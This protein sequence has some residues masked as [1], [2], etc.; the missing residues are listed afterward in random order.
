MATIDDYTQD[1]TTTGRLQEGGQISAKFEQGGD[2]D[3]FRITLAA[4]SYYTFQLAATA[5]TDG[6]GSFGLYLSQP[7]GGML[8]PVWS[9]MSAKGMTG[10]FKS[11]VAGDYFISAAN[12]TYSA[13][14]P[15]SYTL[16]AGA[17]VADDA[18]D[19]EQTA[20]RIALRQAVSGIFE[21]PGDVDAYKVTLE[22]GV[23]YTA[24]QG[25]DAGSTYSMSV[26]VADSGGQAV[27]AYLSGN[28]YSFTAAASGDYYFLASGGNY[29]GTA[30]PYTLT[31]EAAVDDRS[32]GIAGAGAL[33]VGASTKGQLEV[34]G[35]KDWYA[36]TLSAGQVYWLTAKPDHSVPGGNYS[37]GYAQ[38]QLFDSSGKLLAA[39]TGASGD[40]VLQYVPTRTGTYYFEVGASPSSVM[41][42]SYLAHAA[43]G[44]QDDYGNDRAGARQV[45]VGSTT[46]GK[47][48]LASD[49]DMFKF[50]VKA[51]STYLFEL[52]AQNNVGS[53][54]LQL[55][56]QDA[57]GSS[58]GLV[59]YSKPGVTDYRIYTASYTGDY[60]LAVDNTSS[61]GTAGYTL[62]VSE[63][64]GDDFAAG[65]ATTAAL[66]TGARLA[67][68]LDYLGDTDWI[69]VSM[70]AGNKYAFVLGGRNSGDGT[71]DTG[72]GQAGL[73]LVS[74]PNGSYYHGMTSL[75]GLS[76]PGYSFSCELSGDYY[77]SVASSS[78]YS[79]GVTGTYTVSAYNISGDTAMPA[80]VSFAPA[81]GGAGASLTGN[82]TLA[83]ND[84]MRGGEGSIRLVD[85]LGNAVETFYM[86]GSSDRVRIA[87]NT[88]TLDPA[89]NLQ[90]GTKYTLE[91]PAGALLD[92]AGNKFLADSVYN[93]TTVDTVAQGGSGNDLLS[94]IGTNVR[95]S[96]GDGIDTVVYGSGWANYTVSVGAA[97]SKVL[98]R[99]GGTVGTG[100]S[101]TGVERLQ[102]SD[103][104][105]AL[106]ADGHGGQAYR[107]YQA[108]FNRAPDKAGLGFWMSHLDN[109]MSLRTVAKAFLDSAEFQSSYGALGNEAFVNNLYANVLHRAGEAAGVAHWVDKLE[110][111][112]ARADVLMGFSESAENSAEILKVI[113]NGFEYTPYG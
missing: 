43:V 22:K 81:S 50:S 56:G 111:G 20:G 64:A 57:G 14:M 47:L 63:P 91:I 31:V 77:L 3:W 70:V 107:M 80:M 89:A 88:V 49:I 82:I 53:P 18:G 26:S 106:D 13:T 1:S 87:G 94:G 37:Y 95:L 8:S 16:S 109:G 41:T 97:E 58:S 103:R 86:T 75:G 44:V 38:L 93:F 4:N 73:A 84:L 23:T 34:A 45:A 39:E 104:S 11:S 35:D 71:L 29:S 17:A 98:Y 9:N 61:A 6:A 46:S 66:A 55:A 54:Y 33:R 19:T 51:G 62:Q 79:G 85:A 99:Y 5:L 60:F 110:H 112:T 28:S 7:G 32:A 65:T 105:I 113:G 96:G 76:T 68:S 21:G 78:Y 69:R 30:S 67:G 83:F 108:A 102:F 52:K 36:V 101:L 100:D 72:N 27:A 40:T 42:G 10:M 92:Y 48:E 90:P 12:Y 25:Y 74:G 59:S 24:R 15:Y 2:S